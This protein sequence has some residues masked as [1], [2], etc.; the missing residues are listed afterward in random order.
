MQYTRLIYRAGQD[1]ANNRGSKVEN[2]SKI[3]Y[4]GAMQNLIFASL[5]S[6][7]FAFAFDDEID[8]DEQAR[9]EQKQI[10]IVNNMVDSILRGTGITGAA[11]ATIKN[12]IMEFYKQE[13][14][15]FNNDHAQTL[16]QFAN[17]APPVGIKFRKIY[18]GIQSYTYNKDIV[19]EMS[20]LDPQNPGVQAV[21]NVIS[22]ATNFPTDRIVNKTNN[23]VEVLNSDN[24][25]WQ[26]LALTLGWNTWD[27]GVEQT[28][29][30]EAKLEVKQKKKEEKKKTQQR[31]TQIKSDG[32][33]CKMMVDKPKKKCHYHD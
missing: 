6:A 26:R 27:V 17:L 18:S 4:Y 30:D 20:Y 22:G 9:L 8:E 32:E 25:N 16:I 11:I 12:T 13:Q 5:Q 3:I 31:C 14:K 21:A 24:E 28:R 1:L 7:L 19:G 29:R 33:I 15:K 10:R 23:L 2:I